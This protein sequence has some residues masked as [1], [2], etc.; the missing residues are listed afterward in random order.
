MLPFEGGHQGH[1]VWRRR[2]RRSRESLFKADAVRRRRSKGKLLKAN[3]VSEEEWGIK[4]KKKEE[5]W[6]IKFLRV[7]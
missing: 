5:E 1:L 7:K 6:G 2:S 3:A 4:F